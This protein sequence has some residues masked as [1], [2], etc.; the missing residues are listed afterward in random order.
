[1]MCCHSQGGAYSSGC[2]FAEGDEGFH[3]RGEKNEPEFRA[4]EHLFF[5]FYKVLVKLWRGFQL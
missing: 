4:A 5:F 2:P 3:P 1:M